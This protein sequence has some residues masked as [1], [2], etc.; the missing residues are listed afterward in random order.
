MQSEPGLER[1]LERFRTFSKAFEDLP[2]YSAL[3][4]S[5]ADDPEVAGLLCRA[6]PGQERPVLLLA[7]VHDLLLAHPA[8]P[9]ARWY[10]S[11]T[12]EDQLAGGDPYP[13]FRQVCIDHAAELRQVIA[14]RS[15]QTNEV[16][17]VALLVPLIARAC[18]DIPSR[19][20]AVVELGCSAGL[21]LGLEHYRTEIGGRVAGDPASPVQLSAEVVGPIGPP[22]DPFPPTL[23]VVDRVGIDLAPVSLDDEDALRWL[24]ACLWPDQ[25]GRLERFRAAVERQ[26]QDP[27]RLVAGDFIDRLPEVV[28]TL[29]SDAHLVVFHCWALTYVVSDRRWVLP[30]VL[31][32]LA[33]GGRPVSWL[34]AEPP[35][36]VPGIDPPPLRDVPEDVTPDTVLGL[37]RWRD[38]SE[39]E[40]LT[41]GWAH[42]HGN[43]L[44]WIDRSRF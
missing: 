20:V 14:T 35:R 7:A 41:C 24:Q 2:L 28:A 21:L 19:P 43:W 30:A 34:S 15:T 17:R 8:L 23:K 25:R 32:E 18:S 33:A 12:P 4:R 44:T 6:R 3:S 40:A 11:I 37:R 22:M 5:I 10:R 38:G 1:I 36:C 31:S 29:P 9:A 26:R 16:N 42:P 27:P 39:Q 13:A